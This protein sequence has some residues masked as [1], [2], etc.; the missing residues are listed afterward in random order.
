MSVA[1]ELAEKQRR[2]SEFLER[3]GLQG[4]LLGTIGNLAW[5]TGGR[6]TRVG[7]ATEVGP[8]AILVTRAGRYLVTDEVEAPRLLAEELAGQEVE[9]LGY[10]WYRADPA[11]AVRRRVAGR[12]AADMAVSGLESL[13][14][15][16]AELR[17]ALTEEEVDRYRWF[18]EHAGVAMTHALL[19]L[20]A[21]LSGAQNAGQLA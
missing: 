19:H 1:A 18:G 5:I 2:V 16:F 15:E 8:A 10:P 9:L 7:A 13:P 6:T 17:W 14:P 3:T 21:G 12:V 4:V 11:A 20:R